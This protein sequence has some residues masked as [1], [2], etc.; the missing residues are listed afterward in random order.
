MSI[1]NICSK[2]STNIHCYNCGHELSSR[3]DTCPSCGCKKH[4]VWH[5]CSA[6]ILARYKF[7]PYCGK[8]LHQPT[9]CPICDGKL[10]I[11]E[12]YSPP[13]EEPC[14]LVEEIISFHKHTRI[15]IIRQR[16]LSEIAC[17]Q[18]KFPYVP[19]PILFAILSDPGF[20]NQFCSRCGY[21]SP[22]GF[23]YCAHCGKNLLFA[24]TVHSNGPSSI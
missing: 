3:S 11:A 13:I 7:C 1:F 23:K 6:G 10:G 20:L 12:R 9:I 19:L 16:G 24:R 18:C 21:S 17:P 14:G 2:P 15:D 5:H 22:A 4:P 8:K